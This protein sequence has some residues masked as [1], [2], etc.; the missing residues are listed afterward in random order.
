MNWIDYFSVAVAM[1]GAILLGRYFVTT[2]VFSSLLAGTAFAGAVL[3]TS[4]WV[5][6][7]LSRQIVI[8]IFI[9]AAIG[10]L[11]QKNIKPRLAAIDWRLLVYLVLTL[12]LFRHFSYQEYF[13]NNHDPAYWGYA[14]ELLKADYFGPIRM[15]T[16][17]P[18]QI[19]P[20]HILP[21]TAVA[22]LSVFLPD[23]TLPKLIEVRYLLVSVVFAGLLYRLT[24]LAGNRAPFLLLGA[25]CSFYVFEFEIGYNVLI[26]SY[27]YVLL[28]SELMLLMTSNRTDA[29]AILFF[30]LILT[31]AR[32]PITYMAIGLF[33]YYWFYFQRKQI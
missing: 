25:V 12:I 4:G 7:G 6:P 15:P 13:Y 26:S 30:S 10:Q 31:V 3:A 1:L 20:T 32:G 2:T 5:V 33:L 24:S 23:V 16:F 29:K 14:F 17:Y 8:A 22:S 18:E 21:S 28:L 11:L 19:A 27:F 9:A